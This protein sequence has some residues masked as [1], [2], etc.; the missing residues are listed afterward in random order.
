M[1]RQVQMEKQKQKPTLFLTKQSWSPRYKVFVL[2]TCGRCHPE[3]FMVASFYNL[4]HSSVS[5]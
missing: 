2:S 3:R 4:K 5:N 1:D